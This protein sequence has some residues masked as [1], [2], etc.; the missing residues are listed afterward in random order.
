MA[1]VLPLINL[2]HS[3]NLGTLLGSSGRQDI[4]K[5]ITSSWNNNRPSIFG[6]AQDKFAGMYN[7]LM[8]TIH[9]SIQATEKIVKSVGDTLFNRDIICP[10]ISEKDLWNINPT[11]QWHLIHHEPLRQLL[12]EEKV[13]GWEY[14]LEDLLTEDVVGRMITNGEWDS[15]SDE[16][17]LVWYWNSNDPDLSEEELETIGKSREYMTKFIAKQLK[18]DKKDPTNLS[19]RIGHAN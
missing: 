6:T 1:N 13:Y 14:K 3:P 11:M 5:R 18:G 9:D 19:G 10:V 8:G 2:T 17:S 15:N 12:A 4:I 16:E 7:N